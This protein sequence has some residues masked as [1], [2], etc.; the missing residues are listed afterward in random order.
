M[1]WLQHGRT[2]VASE[3]F[4]NYLR[5]RRDN[6]FADD[7]WLDDTEVDQNDSVVLLENLWVEPN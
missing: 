1:E 4:K 7:Q 3:Y 6:H 5:D 2:R